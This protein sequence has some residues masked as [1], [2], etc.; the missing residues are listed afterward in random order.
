MMLKQQSKRILRTLTLILA[1]VSLM[2]LLICTHKQTQ[3][4]IVIQATCTE[5]G[6]EDIVCERCEKVLE[7]KQIE[8]IG[9]NFGEYV[10]SI[11]P[12]INSNG[13]ESAKCNNCT[14]IDHREYIC[15]H[16]DVENV[17]VIEPTCANIGKQDYVCAKCKTVI[18]SEIIDMLNHTVEQYELT[19]KPTPTENGIQSGL[20]LSCNKLVDI[21]YICP[22][23]D[24]ETTIVFDPT[25]KEEGVSE[26]LCSLCKVVL[27][28]Q[29][30]EKTKCNYS[31]WEYS[32]FATPFSDGERYHT[33]TYCGNSETN[34]YSMSMPSANSLYI[35]GT[36][37]CNNVKV[38]NM[39]Q[40]AVDSYDLVC[41][42]DYYGVS[43]TW[44]LG[45]N[46]GSMK[47]LH[48]TAVGQNIYLSIDGNIRTYVVRYSEFAMQNASWTNIIG[49]TS[50]LSI[51]DDI[52]G[53]EL[54]MY[55]CY[56]GTNGRWM[57]LAER[58]G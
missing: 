8:A 3:S 2:L 53:D 18:D 27:N 46:Y 43:G 28:T 24:S 29:T 30:L 1:V 39:S 49:Q 54:R 56:G 57:V 37:I 45:H 35:P 48:K 20:C 13:Q 26:T 23:E 55:T 58:I 41:D 34:S 25:C 36:G 17:V 51:F 40:T 19:T 16:I 52:P 50:G 7:S 10:I 12:G 42:T 47:N 6:R 21:E 32:K 38:G 31:D 9:H 15:P 22:H 4:I 5:V 44:V 33:C 14:T 11:E